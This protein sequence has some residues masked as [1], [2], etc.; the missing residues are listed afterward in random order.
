M[1]INWDFIIS[2]LVKKF[3]FKFNVDIKYFLIFIFFFKSLMKGTFMSPY[4]GKRLFENVPL[5][6]PFEMIL[7]LVSVYRNET[8]STYYDF[9]LEPILYRLMPFDHIKI[10]RY[11]IDN[12]LVSALFIANYF[13]IRLSTGHTPGMLFGP[14]VRSLSSIGVESGDVKK[15]NYIDKTTM[16]RFL[17]YRLYYFKKFVLKNFL[18]YKFLMIRFFKIR[19]TFFNYYLL[20]YS[21]YFLV[22]VPNLF[23]LIGLVRN[24][25]LRRHVF[26]FFFNYEFNIFLEKIFSFFSLVLLN[27]SFNTSIFFDNIFDDLFSNFNLI[28]FNYDYFNIDLSSVKTANYF[29]NQIII[30]NY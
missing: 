29:F 19:F 15:T 21:I 20:F 26:N 4:G 7:Q 14:V 25:F 6:R 9:S 5:E 2:Y 30:Y 18:L 1:T 8:D 17:S 13:A 23:L 27:F 16:G 11:L 28:F 22:C 10:A 12:S 3:F 24:F